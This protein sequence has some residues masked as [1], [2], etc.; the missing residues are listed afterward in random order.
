LVR[1]VSIL[2]PVECFIQQSPSTPS[3]QEEI[4]LSL[5]R[6]NVAR[7]ALILLLF[8]LL[9][10]LTFNNLDR[11]FSHT[12]NYGSWFDEGINLDVAA[13]IVREGKYGSYGAEGFTLFPE[14]I[15]TGPTVIFPVAL[16]FSLFGI[17]LVQ[18]R[19]IPAIY[20]LLCGLLFYV[21]ADRLYGWKAA[22]LASIFFIVGMLGDPFG[23]NLYAFDPFSHG[24]YALGEIPGFFFWLLGVWMWSLAL[25]RDDDWKRYALFAFAGVSWGLAVQT[26]LM[27]ALL[28]PPFLIW[29]L[30]DRRG[31]KSVA[32]TLV[33]VLFP[34]LIWILYQIS[35]VGLEILPQRILFGWPIYGTAQAGFSQEPAV[36]VSRLLGLGHAGF[37]VLGLPSLAYALV[38]I[39]TERTS[40]R[41]SLQGLMLTFC[42]I[43]LAWW[44]VS[45]LGRARHALPAV[46]II[47]IFF[48][49]FL[50]YLADGFKMPRK[51][52]V[53]SR[54]SDKAFWDIY[55]R[56]LLVG[57]LVILLVLNPASQLLVGVVRDVESSP[58]EV[59]SYIQNSGVYQPTVVTADREL[60]FLLGYRITEYRWRRD[61]IPDDP[62][63]IVC[64]PQAKAHT[65]CPPDIFADNTYLDMTAGAYDVYRVIQK[66]S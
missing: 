41:R 31:W 16:S 36:L 52:D 63:F 62:M 32:V 27:F 22:V 64:G 57:L 20:L 24:H 19:I 66:S 14:E 13:N 39:L 10:F 9:A 23:Q 43:W 38:L 51:T 29:S 50:V 65:V 30:I 54:L 56:S 60:E 2:R 7:N 46:F 34:A 44:T 1:C 12:V 6:D 53:L 37:I 33:G 45:A 40:S 55:G 48:A 5:S 35:V 59:A 3:L 61:E 49:N 26:K 58:E 42:V 11:Y 4:T 15:T 28:I 21:V 8:G 25:D 47:N 18:A 17:G